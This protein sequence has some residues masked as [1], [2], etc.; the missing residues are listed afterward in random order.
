MDAPLKELGK[1]EK[2]TAGESG[3]GNPTSTSE[4]LDALIHSLRNAKDAIQSGTASVSPDLCVQISQTVELKKKEVE[5]R[6]KEIY[7]SISRLGKA[8]D[9]KFSAALPSYPDVFTS[10]TS[11]T[12]L[13]RTVAIHLLR[14][15]QFDTAGIFLQECGSDIPAELRAQFVGLH[16]ILQALRNQDITPAL[17][18]VAKNRNFLR[19]R[20]SPLEFHLHRSQYIRLLL[21]THPPS[22]MQAIAYAKETMA[23]FYAENDAEFKRLTACIAYL[24]LSKLQTSPYADLASPSLH[25]DLE[26][27][28]AKEYCASLGMSR[29]V[30]L[31]VVGDIGG[32]GALARIEK[33]RKVMR[34]R[35]SEWSQSDELPIEIP[36]PPENR[37]HSI[38]ACPVSKEQ[39]TEANPP[40]MMTCGHVVT[41][42]SLHK[43]SK[44]GGCS[45]DPVDRRVK[46]PYCPAESTHGSALRVPTRTSPPS[47]LTESLL[48][49]TLS[50]DLSRS[51]TV[52]IP[53]L[54]G[55]TNEEV[56]LLDAIISR[57]GPTATTFPAIFTAYNAV[58]KERDLDSSEVIYYGKLLKLGT[59]KGS[60]W[61]EKWKMVKLKQGYDDFSRPP[62]RL[63][64]K[65]VND[66]YARQTHPNS[67]AS[68]LTDS[69]TLHSHE[70][71]STHPSSDDE[72]RG[73]VNIPQY[74][75]L[76]RPSR[77][78]VSPV[79]SEDS[80]E[81]RKYP[82]LGAPHRSPVPPLRLR[83]EA[84]S[85]D[86]T[87]HRGAPSTTPPSYRAAIREFAPTKTFDVAESLM[88]KHPDSLA[89]ATARRRV[90]QARERKGS[91]VNEDDAWKKVKMLQ[92]E[93]HADRFRQDKLLD[94]CWEVWKQGFHWI[95]ITN[96]QIAEARDN[97]ILRVRINQWR[98]RTAVHSELLGRVANL[99]NDRLLRASFTTWKAVTR[100]K[101]QVRWRGSMR[102]KM[103]F[104]RDK[105][106]S[107]L[108]TDAL[109]KWKQSHDI[110][111]A[112]QHCHRTL[113]VR[114]C[115]WWRKKLGHIDQI[116]DL[117]N[118]LSRVAD[119]GVLEKSWYYWKHASQLQLAYR[120]VT[121]NV[122]L[123]VKTEVMDVWRKHMRDHNAADT[124]Y[125]IV[126]KRTVL[127]R[128]KAA[129]D[130][131]R[132]MEHRAVTH[133]IHQDRLLLC[134]VYTVIRARY[135][136][137]RL[138]RITDVRRLRE[139]W[140]VWRIRL[141]QHRDLEGIALTFSLRL[142][143]PL[144]QISLRA[145]YQVHSNHKNSQSFAMFHYADCVRRKILLVWRIKLRD[146][147][148]MMSKAR[149]VD[150]FLVIRSTWTTMRAKFVE[151]RRQSFLK[152]LEM[153]KTR[154]LFYAWLEQA[155]RRRVQ[156]LAEE[157]IRSR[158]VKRIL[159]TALTKW[160]NR[161]IDVKNREWQVVIDRDTWVISVA[162]K[163]WKFARGRHVE[164]VSLME[165]YQFVKREE[166]LRK[167]FHR[168][169][170]AARTTRHRRLTLERKQ[171]D[172][173][174]GVISVAWDKWRDRFKHQSLQPI[175][176][177]VIL[178]RHRNILF[179]EFTIWHSK[180]KSLPAIRFHASRIKNKHWKIW[181][182]ALPRALQTKDAREMEKKAVLSKFLNRWLQA[183]R[184]KIALKAVA[185]ARYLR[186]PPATTRSAPINSRPAAP[187]ISRSVFPRRAVR[188]EE[189]VSND[190]A[191]DEDVGPSWQR[192]RATGPR[193]LRSDTSPPRRSRS[194]FSVPVT[195]ASSPSR[196]SV[197]MR[198]GRDTAVRA[199][200]TRSTNP[201]SG[202]EGREPGGLLR[203]LRQLQRRPGSRGR[204]EKDRKV[205]VVGVLGEC[206]NHL[207]RV[208]KWSDAVTESSP[209][210]QWAAREH[211]V[212]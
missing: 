151:R 42:D 43:L 199:I 152:A 208:E 26:P 96:Q 98:A 22:A 116:V 202:E 56:D 129:R 167:L 187:I 106:E 33:G 73:S 8:L 153:R 204:Y 114:Y 84:S 122:G 66:A 183:Y 28:F 148:K 67:K 54:I 124:F 7:S 118:E 107:R 169:L 35:K 93:K 172:I 112:D 180:T 161:T 117:A 64:L 88:T 162:F 63:A 125:D 178:Q 105:R 175:E 6:Q 133:T 158:I 1:L 13:E 132:A 170:S 200:P 111:T 39:S 34:E 168:W 62:H 46:C 44:P 193:S 147:H 87:E 212:G 115:S 10:S 9:K 99:A 18:W 94:R 103:K 32:G 89:L 205:L 188:T 69:L 203:E 164:E 86:A 58:L 47:K 82:L 177:D 15:G 113:L 3:K 24:P 189:Q 174:F 50:A 90:A 126:L 29:Q 141:Q 184:T 198:L 176:Y 190:D 104:I 210:S 77:R 155:H 163:R 131:I 61:T 97:L 79:Y 201:D 196:S 72:E 2:S 142:R 83:T 80:L 55:L 76:H 19:E 37:Y 138:Q 17:G 16:G 207:R 119:H 45:Y 136:G 121:D 31:R 194:R 65:P 206:I 68:H 144:A 134:A 36:L 186:L 181:L 71:E 14:T 150:K 25:F 30:P 139:A 38:F 146:K 52:S 57:A 70:Y 156:R 40:M 171:A 23:P 143:S 100:E 128:W 95:V 165:S 154:D 48:T 41:K 91:V 5:D 109:V 110:R 108:V 209:K 157:E 166:N 195:R 192:K 4:S 130:R 185:R 149:A 92:D 27:L 197:G 160:T 123:R 11:V 60:S 101:Q 182:E 49:S 140:E 173:Q 75:L 137:R 12:A 211:S 74:H 191:S 53:E 145:W 85:S 78:P 51:S 81:S 127:R 120:I 159:H 59:L 21:S 135:Q 20:S 102:S 179:R